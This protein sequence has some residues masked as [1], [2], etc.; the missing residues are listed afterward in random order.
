MKEDEIEIMKKQNRI[1][2][3]NEL[4]LEN[5]ALC[6]EIEKI[7]ETHESMD[8]TKEL[9]TLQEN[10]NKLHK[11]N[12]ILQVELKSKNEEILKLK[13]NINEK[14]NDITYLK[15]ELDLQN[16]INSKKHDS[17]IHKTFEK[18]IDLMT[19]EISNYKEILKY[20]FLI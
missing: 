9:I 20:F 6:E 17:E 1:S 13:K 2:K 16:D 19:T 12:V 8:N 3:Y 10:C 18:K 11:Q 4:L 15:K 14:N 7:K 5:Q